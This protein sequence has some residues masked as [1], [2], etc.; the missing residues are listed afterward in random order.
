MTSFNRLKMCNNSKHFFQSPSFRFFRLPESIFSEVKMTAMPE[1]ERFIRKGGITV[2][3]KNSTQTRLTQKIVHF[4]LLSI[5]VKLT[6]LFIHIRT[7]RQKLF[8][9]WLQMP[10]ANCNNSTD[11]LLQKIGKINLFFS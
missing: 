2:S 7:K 1:K 8:F 4:L 3:L 10:T 6:L 5:I 9:C 11:K